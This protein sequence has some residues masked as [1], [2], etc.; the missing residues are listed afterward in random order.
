MKR[1]D[2]VK[3]AALLPVAPAMVAASQFA[4]PKQIPTCRDESTKCHNHP[5]MDIG[6]IDT[7]RSRIDGFWVTF[8]DV[9]KQTNFL[10]GRLGNKEDFWLNANSDFNDFNTVYSV[11]TVRISDSS[12]VTK[13]N[14]GFVWFCVWPGAKISIT[15]PSI[16]IE[17]INPSTSWALDWKWTRETYKE[18]IIR[19]A[20]EFDA[21][22]PEWLIPFARDEDVPQ[23]QIKKWMWCK[24]HSGDDKI[25]LR[26][27]FRSNVLSGIG[28]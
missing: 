23:T 7:Q 18:T 25:A 19:V 2:F 3:I 14:F 12:E 17:Q 1:R 16:R 28:K 11:E 4:E 22:Y 8:D 24:K 9:K 5:K 10:K 26:S 6:S 20:T 27:H 13:I 21:F 15:E